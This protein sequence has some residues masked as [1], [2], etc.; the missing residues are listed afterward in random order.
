MD[1]SLLIHSRLGHQN[2]SKFRIMVSCFSSLSS[3]EYESSQ[4]VK[5]TRFPFPKRL[6]QRTKSP[7]ELVY[8]DVWGPSLTKSTLGFWYFITFID[9]HS[10]CTWLFLRKTRAELFSIFQKFHAEVRTQFNTSI[11][12]LQSDNVKEYLSGSFS[13]FLPS[14]GVLHEPSY[15]YNSQ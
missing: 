7:F 5:Y 15:A 4:L 8:I 13:S 10:R 6:D 3:I 2:V 11:R 9:D 1:T 14:H 12:I